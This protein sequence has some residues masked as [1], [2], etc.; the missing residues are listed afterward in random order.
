MD[1]KDKYI[2]DVIEKYTAELKGIE[3]VEAAEIIRLA[4][5][6]REDDLQKSMKNLEEI[7]IHATDLFNYLLKLKSKKEETN[8][9]V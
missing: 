7:I 9:D 4:C 8:A 2:L 3:A 6:W 5:Y 1:T